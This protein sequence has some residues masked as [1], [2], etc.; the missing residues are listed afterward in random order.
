MW[1]LKEGKSEM[2]RA[3]KIWYLCPSLFLHP[4]C[5]TPACHTCTLNTTKPAPL[6]KQTSSMKPGLT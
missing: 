1:E 5:P 6:Q 3:E 2:S 4:V